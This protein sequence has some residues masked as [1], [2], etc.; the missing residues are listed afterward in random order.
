MIDVPDRSSG[1]IIQNE[2][3]IPGVEQGFGQVGSD[4]P[5][6]PCDECSHSELVKTCQ[7]AQAAAI[8]ATVAA[9]QAEYS[10]GSTV[11]RGHGLQPDSSTNSTTGYKD[12]SVHDLP[13]LSTKRSSQRFASGP[14]ALTCRQLKNQYRPYWQR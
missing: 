5:S 7:L 2:D 8:Q 9:T 10:I 1:E 6:A 14:A 12:S 3:V 13:P 4:E 11:S